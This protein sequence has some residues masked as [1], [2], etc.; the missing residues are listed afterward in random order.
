M[1]THEQKMRNQHARIMLLEHIL[2]AELSEQSVYVYQSKKVGS[3]SLVRSLNA[4]GV[5]SVH[6]HSF[7]D[8]QYPY[9]LE[10]N[11]IRSLIKKTSGKVI[12]IVRDPIARQV[13]LL[14][15]LWG[16]NEEVFL[17]QYSSL[18]EIEK[19][20]YSIPNREDE[21]QW[22]K[23]EFEKILNIN[24]YDYP[25]ERERGYSI[26]EKDGISVL[27]IKMEKINALKEVIGRF[28]G[29]E[30]FKLLNANMAVSKKY[31]YAYQNYLEHIKIPTDFF[32][33]YYHGNKYMDYFYTEEEKR[34]MGEKWCPGYSEV[35]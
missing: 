26:I 25:F 12:S 32:E 8:I 21:F 18:E 22:Y 31:F 24:I 19:N 16:T 11:L 5:Y 33:Y 7:A 23:E 30:N 27:L 2:L 20:F 15:H 9:H 1:Q 4:A 14:W 13:S 35:L 29:I 6:V 34:V 10:E 3:V 17:D 28:C